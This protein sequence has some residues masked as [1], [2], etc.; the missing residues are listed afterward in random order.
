MADFIEAFSR[1][2]HRQARRGCALALAGAMLASLLVV[3]GPAGPAEAQVSTH[4]EVLVV[5]GQVPIPAIEELLSWLEAKELDPRFISDVALTSVDVEGADLVVLTGRARTQKLDHSVLK[6]AAVPVL[7]WGDDHVEALE[8]GVPAKRPET[9]RDL[10]LSGSAGKIVSG[11]GTVI[12]AVTNGRAQVPSATELGD[13]AQVVATADRADGA[14]AMYVYDTGSALVDGTA[15]ESRRIVVPDL[16]ERVSDQALSEVGYIIEW[17]LASIPRIITDGAGIEFIIDP[18]AFA[19]KPAETLGNRLDDTVVDVGFG[20]DANTDAEFRFGLTEVVVSSSNAPAAAAS[21]SAT[22]VDEAVA[23]DGVSS[24]SRL[25]YDSNTP[26]EPA[27]LLEAVRSRTPV[28]QSTVIVS[29]ADAMRVLIIAATLDQA[30]M[31]A[32]PNYLMDPDDIASG[33]TTDAPNGPAGVTLAGPWNSDAFTWSHLVDGGPMDT[34]VTRAWQKMAAVGALES[35][36]TEVGIIDNGFIS[37]GDTPVGSEFRSIRP[38]GA[39]DV[40]GGDRAPWHGVG[41]TEAAVGVVDNGRGGAGPGGPVATAV[42][43]R[44]FYDYFT[45]MVSVSAAV[46]SGAEVVNMSFSGDIPF[47]VAFTVRPFDIYTIAMSLA[48]I[49]LIASAGNGDSD[50]IP[51]DV[52]EEFCVL[53]CWELVWHTPCE[54]NGVVCVGALGT[55]SAASAAF[56]NFGEQVDIWAPGQIPLGL[57]PDDGGGPGAK[58]W[59]GTSFSSPFTAGAVALMMSANPD[60]S[61][62]EAA[63]LLVS[64]SRT[65]PGVVTA[66][67][68]VDAALDA[69][70]LV[71]RLVLAD[72][73]ALPATVFSG[74]TFD[75]SYSVLNTSSEA[76]EV[77]DLI[78]AVRGPDGANLDAACAFSGSIAPGATQTCTVAITLDAPG[79]H[80]I[81]PAWQDQVG[82]WWRLDDSITTDVRI[83]DV[84]PAAAN[85]FDIISYNVQF[86]TPEY[87]PFAKVDDAHWPNTVSRA[88]L[89]SQEIVDRYGCPDVINLQETAGVERTDALLDELNSLCAGPEYWI[90]Y[91]PQLDLSDTEHALLGL[92]D[93]IATSLPDT[94]TAV[95]PILDDEMAIITNLNGVTAHEDQ[96]DFATGR[97]FQAAKGV[98][99]LRLFKPGVGLIDVFNTHLNAGPLPHPT[100]Y[101]EVG[102]MLAAHTEADVPWVLAGDFN[103]DPSDDRWPQLLAQVARGAGGGALVSDDAR[104]ATAPS[105][106]GPTNTSRNDGDIIGTILGDVPASVPGDL[107]PGDR[108]IDHV[109]AGNVVSDATTPITV[110]D[111]FITDAIPTEL[112]F[113]ATPLPQPLMMADGTQ[114]IRR[115]GTASDH[116]A[117]W[118]RFRLLD[119]STPPSLPDLGVTRELQFDWSLISAIT[120]DGGLVGDRMEW[121]DT[122]VVVSVGGDSR[123]VAMRDRAGIDTFDPQVTDVFVLP[124]GERF[125][126]MD[127]RIEED[128]SPLA[129]DTVDINPVR[130]DENPVFSLDTLTGEISLHGTPIGQIGNPITTQGSANP[131][132]E[133]ARSAWTARVVAN[134]DSVVRVTVQRLTDLTES[135]AVDFRGELILSRVG[136]GQV[137]DVL[138]E[139]TDQDD[140]DPP[141]NWSVAATAPPGATL[142]LTILVRDVDGGLRFD[143]DITDISPVVGVTD[144][145]LLIDSASGEIR[146]DGAVVGSIGTP[147]VLEGN[148]DGDAIGRITFIVT[149]E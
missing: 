78:V 80:E 53:L 144:L 122:R 141:P 57:D 126:T 27:R 82:T 61:A 40:R 63:S 105:F 3:T 92:W 94:P 19:D 140:L 118:N 23:P 88:R 48:G 72:A 104:C 137:V 107:T 37:T 106:C 132:D 66:T 117:I 135:E 9:F 54:N 24:L 142:P 16:T 42:M 147:V 138:P 116:A 8:L 83:F 14:P 13:G 51:I 59:S 127:F 46:A 21:L 148:G 131:D 119:R 112:L 28:E 145:A 110:T 130:P 47:V 85:D 1:V 75:A 17:A 32:G 22:I 95:E 73:L 81:W 100:Q 64:T 109:F 33:S 56:S 20:L 79:V 44:S 62:T 7:T 114:A 93:E 84:P 120:R 115:Y 15:A 18:S 6:S 58:Q 102:D 70:P 87:Y 108:R 29:S 136:G 103:T 133:S 45:A 89:L 10:V 111:Y 26:V 97:D 49:A 96:F 149:I 38:G 25:R 50:G 76:I 43:V 30:D 41:V 91:G 68:D 98:L 99:H 69:A 77:V 39:A 2:V 12:P 113:V 134:D 60:L 35:I 11:A 55:S 124:A 5:G 125:V 65:G 86:L 139:Q 71:S 128:D 67:I 34:G 36:G 31:A 121:T 129:D 101:V 143:D 90:Y 4:P 146:L 123:E 74:R 52:D